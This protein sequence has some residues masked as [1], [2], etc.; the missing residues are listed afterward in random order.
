MIDIKK[1]EEYI[2]K[3]YIE[4][5]DSNETDAEHRTLP[6]RNSLADFARKISGRGG[7]HGGMNPFIGMSPLKHPDFNTL[8]EKLSNRQEDFSERLVYY[9]NKK[10]KSHP[11]VYNAAG[12]TAD[13]FSKLLSGKSKK[14]N[15]ENTI[16]LAFA[17][18]LKYDE[19]QDFIASAGYSFPQVTKKEDVIFDYCFKNG[20][21]TIDEVNEI[22][23]YFSCKPIGGRA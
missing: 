5:D 20:P 16:A 1:L 13:C 17:M 15:R 2:N 6:S 22:L 23:C 11:Q 7:K 18:E 3:N 21:H 9:I 4:S 10:G 12:I 8:K 19:A 14:P